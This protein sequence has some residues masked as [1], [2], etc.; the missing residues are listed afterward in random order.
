MERNKI[1]IGAIA[2]VLIALIGF[3]FNSITGNV[4]GNLKPDVTVFP[5]TVKAGEKINI[6]VKPNKG[7]VDPEIGF[8]FSG[9]LSDGTIRSS[10]GRKGV[11]THK[12]GYKVCKGNG[13]ILDKDGT[14]T[15][16]YRTEPNWDGEHFAK[17][18][19]WKDRNT[20]DSVNAYFNVLPKEE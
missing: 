5:G 18:F 10:G 19:Y 15:V 2:I 9:K 7:C 6:K 1:L 8:Y 20:K 3:N 4:V 13:L 11:V 12:G 17:I 16:G 14:F